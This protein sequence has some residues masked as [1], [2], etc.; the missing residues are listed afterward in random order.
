[1]TKTA[2]A[3]HLSPDELAAELE[4]WPPEEREYRRVEIVTSPLFDM[5]QR[6]L[7]AFADAA[8]RAI[9]RFNITDEDVEAAATQMEDHS[10]AGTAFAYA[11]RQIASR[12]RA[13]ELELHDPRGELPELTARGL[14]AVELAV[15]EIR[16]GMQLLREAGASREAVLESCGMLWDGT[17]DAVVG[18]TPRD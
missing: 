14:S 1:M 13:R 11:L 2:Y 9:D 18:T 6:F 15:L 4:S 5:W 8:D 17:I 3:K 10:P 7:D 16:A 12:R